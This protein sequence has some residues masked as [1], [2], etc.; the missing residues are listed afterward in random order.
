MNDFVEEQIG[1]TTRRPLF[2][3][4]VSTSLVFASMAAALYVGW[5]ITT[6]TDRSE[7]VAALPRSVAIPF[8]GS[9]TAV[10]E[11][12]REAEVLPRSAPLADET[13]IDDC[14]EALQW[15]DRVR[16]VASLVGSASIGNDAL[17]LGTFVDPRMLDKVTS[18]E[19]IDSSD[20]KPC[21]TIKHWE[22]L[23]STTVG[24]CFDLEQKRV[25]AGVE[26]LDDSYPQPQPAWSDIEGTVEL[27]SWNWT[28]S[29]LPSHAILGPD[30]Q[31]I[32]IRYDLSGRRGRE[33]HN[34]RGKV[35]LTR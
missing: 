22:G 2:G 17:R 16:E 28:P 35:V 3:W 26:S 24:L 5:T 9:E 18:V 15:F 1:L 20:A 21:V 14:G 11:Q 30:Q 29:K 19:L 10:A 6:R 4:K 13:E 12:P 32:V 33:Q 25:T 23:H 7:R 34:V 31:P 8:P 27:S